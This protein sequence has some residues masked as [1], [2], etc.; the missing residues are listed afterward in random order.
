MAKKDTCQTHNY[1]EENP[2]WTKCQKLYFNWEMFS[3]LLSL[4]SCVEALGLIHGSHNSAQFTN[5]KGKEQ[6]HV[7][8]LSVSDFEHSHP[9]SFSKLLSS[10]NNTYH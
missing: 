3:N 5:C 7:T 6:C 4:L 8:L 1:L 2:R 9:S 10:N